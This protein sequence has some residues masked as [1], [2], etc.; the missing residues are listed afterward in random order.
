M[1]H[2]IYDVDTVP[3]EDFFQEGGGDL[4]GGSYFEGI[5]YQRGYGRM[6][7]D[8]FGSV[9]RS[10]IRVLWP[11]AKKAGKTVGK[12]GLETGARILHDVAQGTPVEEAVVKETKEGARNI[13]RKFVRKQ[14]GEG[15]K[16]RSRKGRRG[17]KRSRR[18][19]RRR[20][21]SLGFY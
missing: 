2:F 8:G 3:Y 5:P 11:L 19:K 17:A 14:K 6:Y 15:R 10:L 13:A 20:V 9:F 21:D 7:G 16:R 18:T 4:S 12:E 1:V